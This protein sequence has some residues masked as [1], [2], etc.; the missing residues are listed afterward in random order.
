MTKHR[1]LVLKPHPHFPASGPATISFNSLHPKSK[2]LAILAVLR[3]KPRENVQFLPLI[4]VA[5][6]ARDVEADCHRMWQIWRRQSETQP[7][8]K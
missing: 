6:F 7:F 3:S 4:E 1:P 2:F 8:P 5:G